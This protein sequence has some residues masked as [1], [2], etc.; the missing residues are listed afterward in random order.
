MTLASA[1]RPC[2]IY[3][4]SLEANLRGTVTRAHPP[5]PF[6][7][8]SGRISPLSEA[9]DFVYPLGQV[10]SRSTITNHSEAFPVT[11]DIMAAKGCDGLL[12]K[13]CPRFSCG[14]DNHDP[15]DRGRHGGRESIL[16]RRD[17]DFP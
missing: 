9:P 7:F 1:H 14:G 11:V 13:T 6:G 17:L 16:L 8:S 10:S 12:S 15:E 2:W 4:A 3:I 5:R